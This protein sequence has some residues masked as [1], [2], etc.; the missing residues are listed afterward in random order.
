MRL[1]ISTACYYPMNTEDAL[2]AVVEG[3]AP[4]TELFFNAPSELSPKYLGELQAILRGGGTTV[5]SVHPFT[6]AMEPM[7][8]FGNYPRRFEDGL[9]YY[10]RYFDAAAQLGAGYCVLHGAFAHHRVS[11]AQYL[12]SYGRLHLAAK[13][14]G[15]KVAQE[16]VGRCMS[17][18]PQLFRQLRAAISDAAF[19]LDVKQTFRS[20]GSVGEFLAAMGPGLAHL[21]LSDANATAD[22]LPVGE[23]FF[24][25][26]DFFKS[27]RQSGYSG[28]AVLE[29]YRE[30]Y[31]ETSQLW[32]SLGRL[33]KTAK[34]VKLSL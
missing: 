8:F 12:D 29:L 22:C 19:V 25:F 13:A 15:V 10:K 28:D 30:S 5:T 32:S 23:G 31:T 14:C 27:L 7:L 26:L 18:N 9:D 2:A 6:S 1:G 21:H 17:R 20:D 3:G 34:Q 16:N 24:D 11:P 33:Q 4:C